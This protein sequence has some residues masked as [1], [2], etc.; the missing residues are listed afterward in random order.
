MRPH[1]QVKHKLHR[2]TGTP[3][4]SQK[5]VLKDG[6]QPIAHLNDDSKMLGYYS[7]QS[8]M[9]IHIIETDPFSMSRGG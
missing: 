6:G 8:G 9:E 7:A 1:E 4:C 2:H 3:A 5:L